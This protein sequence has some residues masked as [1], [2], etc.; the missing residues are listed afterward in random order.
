MAGTATLA[1]DRTAFAAAGGP[2]EIVAREG[3]P[4]EG[5]GGG[6]LYGDSLDAQL[7]EG[8]EFALRAHLKTGIGGIKTNDTVIHAPAAI[9]GHVP[10]LREGDPAPGALDG[11]RVREPGLI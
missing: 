8:G 11:A 6:A 10:L 2:V 9:G 1:N 5:I 3:D 7:T 4:A